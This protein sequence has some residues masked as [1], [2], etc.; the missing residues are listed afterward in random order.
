MAVPHVWQ[1]SEIHALPEFGNE[2]GWFYGLV[3]GGREGVEIA[4]II[5]GI[6]WTSIDTGDM[7]EC[8]EQISADLNTY[9]PAP[10]RPADQQE[11]DRR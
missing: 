3:A 11:G 4:E 10:T 9:R 7:G 8:W 5:P 6:G 1:I 2:H